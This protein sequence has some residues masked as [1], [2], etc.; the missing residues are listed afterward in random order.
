MKTE[1]LSA[2]APGA[3]ERAVAV[4]RRGGLVA[5]PTDTVYGVGALA[6]DE[7]TVKKL[8]VIKGRNTDKAIAVLLASAE[9]AARVTT[10]LTPVGRRLAE[11]FWPGPITLILPKHP[12][13]PEAVSSLPTVGVRVP[14][15]PILRKILAEA[16]PLAVTS[17]NRSGEEDPV[18]AQS[19]L[20]RLKNRFDMLLDG[21]ATPGGVPSTIVDC[22][23][24]RPRILR[25][26][27]IKE[28]EILAAAQ[29]RGVQRRT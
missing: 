11:A 8:Y 28:E 18:S 5:F 3:A 23:S 25:P 12:R 6:F 2:T 17:A 10:G 15:H 24:G 27:P 21:G 16:G 26:G 14:N 29:S 1:I 19:V 4:L 13:L 22:T 7:E 20:A 9:D